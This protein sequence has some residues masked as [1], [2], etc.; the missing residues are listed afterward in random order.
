[1]A[2]RNGDQVTETRS[3]EFSVKQPEKYIHILYFNGL[4]YSPRISQKFKKKEDP[5][6]GNYYLVPMFYPYNTSILKESK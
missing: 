4:K 5:N 3:W 6:Q 2:D 1:M